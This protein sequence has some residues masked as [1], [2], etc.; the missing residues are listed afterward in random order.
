MKQE[1]QSKQ[2]KKS[3]PVGTEQE[4]R[5]QERPNSENNITMIAMKTIILVATKEK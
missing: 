5:K 1:T 2:K 3:C 4:N